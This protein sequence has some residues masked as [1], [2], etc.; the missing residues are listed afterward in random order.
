MLQQHILY[1]GKRK[2]QP[3]ETRKICKID[4]I[5]HHPE[6]ERD[7][8]F[9]VLRNVETNHLIPAY[10]SRSGLL[11]HFAS[12]NDKKV[13]FKQNKAYSTSFVLDIVLQKQLAEALSEALS[14]S[15]ELEQCSNNRFMENATF[16]KLKLLDSEL[17]GTGEE[18]LANDTYV[19]EFAEIDD[20]IP[21]C[22]LWSKYYKIGFIREFAFE[23][24]PFHAMKKG[25]VFGRYK[26]SWK[27][28]IPFLSQCT[29][30]FHIGSVKD[31]SS[32]DD[33][34]KRH[35]LIQTNTGSKHLRRVYFNKDVNESVDIHSMLSQKNIDNQ[36]WSKAFITGKSDYERYIPLSEDKFVMNNEFAIGTP[37]HV[38]MV[39]LAINAHLKGNFMYEGESE[40][41]WTSEISLGEVHS[42][43][44]FRKG[45]IVS[46][47]GTESYTLFD[48]TYFANGE[49]IPL[50]VYLLPLT[51]TSL[52]DVDLFYRFYPV[53]SQFLCKAF[54]YAG[55]SLFDPE[56]PTH[57]E[58]G[59]S[60]YLHVGKH[61]NGIWPFL[62]S[63]QLLSLPEDDPR[64]F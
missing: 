41:L 26:K 58:V 13:L 28:T 20:F 43:C 24:D 52:D 54:E 16:S 8:Y 6:L 4:F 59:E 48:V 40:V 60:S 21:R 49:H 44:E 3:D 29:S 61:L 36:A 15:K 35:V 63:S 11:W 2:R 27:Q 53:A 33:V 42:K 31:I 10:R 45:K 30:V 56:M 46:R 51:E 32:V 1:Q 64:V 55:Q 9:A 7:R 39:K 57:E 62:L 12:W 19:F 37:S 23:K 47:T 50:P 17:D 5:G 14:Q 22:G 34:G 18:P 25:L 38:E